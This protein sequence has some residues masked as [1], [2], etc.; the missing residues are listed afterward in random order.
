VDVSQGIVTPGA[1]TLRAEFGTLGIGSNAVINFGFT[2]AFFGLNTNRAEV[3]TS[4][5]DLVL[6]NNSVFF[7]IDV[8]SSGPPGLAQPVALSNGVFQFELSG[9]SFLNYV[10]EATTNLVDWSPIS[11]NIPVGGKITFMDPA[12][13]QNPIRFYRARLLG[14]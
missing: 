10:V 4:D 7:V 3:T 8:S 13:A 11:T 2:P 14:N 1:Q 12:A 9:Q 5:V 6:E